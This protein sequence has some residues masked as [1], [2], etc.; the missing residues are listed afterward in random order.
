[1]KA[2]AVGV[3]GAVRII[4][5]CEAIVGAAGYIEGQVK[6]PAES[7]SESESEDSA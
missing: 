5:A 2:L 3:Y 6:R 1:M 7:E 4:V